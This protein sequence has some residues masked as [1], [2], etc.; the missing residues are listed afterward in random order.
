MSLQLGPGPVKA[1]E[2]IALQMLTSLVPALRPESGCACWLLAHCSVVKEPRAPTRDVRRAA[3][4]IS[5]A[6]WPRY[7]VNP[8]RREKRRRPG[9]SSGWPGMC[10]P[11]GSRIVTTPLS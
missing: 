6:S 11:A 2:L 8:R 3:D 9:I 1:L 7:K 4:G 10:S 5:D